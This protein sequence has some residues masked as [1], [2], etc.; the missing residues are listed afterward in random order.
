MDL[1]DNSLE[2]DEAADDKAV[3]TVCGNKV[4]L[5]LKSGKRARTYCARAWL[6]VQQVPSN[7]PSTSYHRA[8]GTLLLWQLAFQVASHIRRYQDTKDATYARTLCFSLPQSTCGLGQRVAHAK[9]LLFLR[10]PV[11]VWTGAS[12]N[13]R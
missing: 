1:K 5:T 8:P 7:L 11:H 10:A 4:N 12:G 13:T 9:T 2:Q 6:L 3:V